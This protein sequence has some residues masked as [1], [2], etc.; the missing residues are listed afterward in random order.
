VYVNFFSTQDP[1][2]SDKI[3]TAD[4]FDE[5]L[6]RI[7]KFFTLEQVLQFFISLNLIATIDGVK[8][9]LSHG[10]PHFHGAI[11]YLGKKI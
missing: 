6:L 10:A 11:E 2:N 4:H 7:E 8:L 9:D 5:T 3:I 1:G